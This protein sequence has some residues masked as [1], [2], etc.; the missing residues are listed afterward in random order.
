MNRQLI[1]GAPYVLALVAVFS[2]S[3]NSVTG[4][5]EIT[6]DDL[7][8]DAARVATVGVTV[9][10]S[11]IAVGDT[12]RAIA[13]LRDYQN[14]ILVRSV[15]WS[16]NNSSVATVDSAGLVTGV[17]EGTAVITA[18]RYG[19]SGSASL[20][21][22]TGVSRTG[23]PGAVGDLAVAASDSTSVTLT[24]TQVDDGTGQP[25]NYDVR[26]AVSPLSW[27]SASSTTSG[28]CT[29]PLSGNA[30]GS[31]LTCTVAG[32]NPVTKYNFE[33]V[34]FRGTLNA[35]AIFGELSN[36]VE[37]TTV[38][39]SPIPVASVTVSP[40]SAAVQAKSTLQLA[41]ITKDANG[42]VLS[43]RGITWASTN[44]S[45]ATVSSTGLVTGV[46]AGTA[47]INAT[48]E[49]K[50]GSAAI[51][52]TA[53]PPTTTN[54]GTVTNLGVSSL[55]STKVILAFTQ[56]DDGSGQPARYDVRFAQSPISWGS[57][58]SVTNGSCATPLI[59]S[60]VGTTLTCTVLALTPAT[61]YDFPCCL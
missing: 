50:V 22:T 59:G 47:Q 31:A 39:S 37:G 25:A 38:A 57:A 7:S 34:A 60:G 46:A 17:S 58:A 4:T 32:L 40:A 42:N 61:R 36:V 21:V 29:T 23:S 52:V 19:K 11:S 53:A 33:L 30:I 14:R 18:A 56:V 6:T 28:T 13:T 15:T 12:T 16:S 48:S 27:G 54:P 20:T 41:A 1:T 8:A 2:C 55:D 24:F 26:Y 45:I 5:D 35:G 51:T 44:N 10:T 9:A 3:E 43:G 49:S